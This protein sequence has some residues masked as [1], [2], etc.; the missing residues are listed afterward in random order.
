MSRKSQARSGG[1]G[2][3]E[4]D[5]ARAALSAFGPAGGE[6]RLVGPGQHSA[7]LVGRVASAVRELMV[8]L[9]QGR[10]VSILP[11]D[12]LLRTQAAADVLNVSR[13]YLVRLLDRGDIPCVR[14]GA[15]RRVR[16]ADLIAYKAR[17]DEQRDAALDRLSELS[18]ADN[19]Y[20]GGDA[21]R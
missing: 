21:D 2:P 10:E 7:V 16:L 9:A 3:S 5:A 18:E 15:H 8:L 19:G 17:R 12:E 1:Q 6:V 14:A 11:R 20:E 13:Q 4:R